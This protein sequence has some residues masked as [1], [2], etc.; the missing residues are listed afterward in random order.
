MQLQIEFLGRTGVEDPQIVDWLLLGPCIS[1]PR[2]TRLLAGTIFDVV[3]R[4]RRD[5]ER[6]RFNTY[7]DPIHRRFGEHI[8]RQTELSDAN[9]ALTE[10]RRPRRGVLIYYPITETRDGRPKPPFTAGFTLLFPPNGISAPPRSSVRRADLSDAPV[11]TV[12]AS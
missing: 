12:T 5:G 7:N 4:S 1:K 6:F 9:A 3:Y 8:A 11:V 10:L 2:A